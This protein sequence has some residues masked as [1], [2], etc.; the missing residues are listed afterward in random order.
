MSDPAPDLGFEPSTDEDNA[1]FLRLR[2]RRLWPI[3][4][5]FVDYAM[6]R[7]HLLNGRGAVQGAINHDVSERVMEAYRAK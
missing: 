2:G 3:D 5:D 1:I 6:L 7:A 4:N